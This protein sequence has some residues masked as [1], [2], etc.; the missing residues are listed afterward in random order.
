MLC[1][2]PAHHSLAAAL[3]QVGLI[4]LASL[5]AGCAGSPVTYYPLDNSPGDIRY[6]PLRP[7]QVKVY[8]TQHP[9][10]YTEL[11][12]LTYGT[13]AWVPDETTVYDAFRRKAAEIGANGVLL[14]PPTEK[15]EY[16]P[17]YYGLR[18]YD[19]T[20]M[21]RT[22]FRGVAIRTPDAA[23]VRSDY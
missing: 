1:N 11:G 4:L 19:H 8:I 14:L 17:V 15:Y 22:T 13:N 20:E 21:T 18:R 5:F 23:A 3:R 10:S 2:A 7:D 9:E 6:A 16:T 12:M